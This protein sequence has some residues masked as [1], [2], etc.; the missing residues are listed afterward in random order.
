MNKIFTR[1][2]GMFPYT[3]EK[4]VD[5]FLK[6]SERDFL[7]SWFNENKEHLKNITKGK[8]IKL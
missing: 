3:G 6:I 7:D 2:I 5:G 1:N 8:N 4:V